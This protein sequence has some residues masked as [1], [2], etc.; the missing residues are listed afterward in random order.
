MGTE[1]AAACSAHLQANDGAVLAFEAQ[2]ERLLD[3][4]QFALV[5][6]FAL[7]PP[8]QLPK[9]TEP[10]YRALIGSLAAVLRTR[11]MTPAE[12]KLN[13]SLYWEV[14]K[15]IELFRLQRAADHF[16][17][18]AEWMPTPGQI[19]S[20]ALGYEHELSLAHR[21]ARRLLAQ[22]D[23]R[24]TEELMNRIGRGELTQDELDALP[25]ADKECAKI[26]LLACD[27]P[28]GGITYRTAQALDRLIAH[29]KR[30]LERYMVEHKTEGN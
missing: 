10:E 27:T 9:V 30:E 23:H 8:P 15:D 4:R 22:R 18:H 3:E 16:I 6:A 12:A 17:K 21:R 5:K 28:E 26:R 14:L 1:L 24:E 11:E 25:D 2:D 20:V 7:L 19:R 13:R 29:N